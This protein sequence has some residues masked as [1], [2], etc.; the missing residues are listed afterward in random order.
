MCQTDVFTAARVVW[1]TKAA[2]KIKTKADALEACVR[3]LRDSRPCG[4]ERVRVLN[5]LDEA[6]LDL[7]TMSRALAF[8]WTIIADELDEIKMEE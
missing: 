8:V 2:D 3:V 5:R 7:G 4:D 6:F 1:M